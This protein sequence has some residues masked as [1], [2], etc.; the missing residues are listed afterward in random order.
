MAERGTIEWKRDQLKLSHANAETVDSL[1]DEQVEQVWDMVINEGYNPNKAVMEIWGASQQSP[2]E[3]WTQGIPVDTNTRTAGAQGF[4]WP[5]AWTQG[6]PVDINKMITDVIG[7]TYAGDEPISKW[8]KYMLN[9][10]GAD[11]SEM[12][13]ANYVDT[14]AAELGTT[15]DGIQDYF[16]GFELGT[17][18]LTGLPGWVEKA[19]TSVTNPYPKPADI[20]GGQWL[21]VNGQWVWQE[22]KDEGYTVPEQGTNMYYDALREMGWAEED[23]PK[24]SP[25][26]AMDIFATQHQTPLGEAPF[27]GYGQTADWNP[28]TASWESR[29]MSSQER[30]DPTLIGS[31]AWA[32]DPNNWWDAAVINR[33]LI[34]EGNVVPQGALQQAT[35]AM[36]QYFNEINPDTYGYEL[37]APAGTQG[38]NPLTLTETPRYDQLQNLYDFNPDD[39]SRLMSMVTPNTGAQLAE[40]W[41]ETVERSYLT[42]PTSRKYGLQ[43]R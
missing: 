28:Y 38:M 36:A 40:P 11:T 32:N 33:S 6:V 12:N 1:S 35:P 37:T 17:D 18:P 27:T 42:Q 4:D 19:E 10:M 14:L 13:P 31:P 22:D 20:E 30:L 43:Y 39:W 25:S 16:E 34:D 21:D 7:V 2:Y 5:S 9:R 26:D 29:A 8:A 15:N 41:Q 24:V 3:G 23:L